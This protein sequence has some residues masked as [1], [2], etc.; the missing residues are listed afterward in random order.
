MP[1]KESKYESPQ[2]IKVHVSLFALQSL[3]SNTGKSFWELEPEIFDE[4]NNVGLR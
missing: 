3:L 2:R 4:V 1:T